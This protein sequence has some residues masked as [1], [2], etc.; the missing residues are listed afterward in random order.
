MPATT[1]LGDF[2]EAW[3]LFA[4][5][6]LTGVILG[7]VLGVLGVY[8]VLGRMVFLSAA[9]SQVAGF[10]VTLAYAAQIHLGIA[11]SLASPTLGATLLSLLCLTLIWRN[12]EQER[13]R[14]DSMLGLIFLVGSAGTLMVASKIIQELHDVKTLLFGSSVAVLPEDFHMVM[15]F[16]ALMLAIHIWWWRGFVEVTYDEDTASVRGMP[17]RLIKLVLIIT[18]AVAVSVCTRVLGALPAFAFSIFPAMAAIIVANNLLRA[19]LIA[20]CIG[21]ASGFLGYLFAFLYD[22]PVGP[23]Q[24]ITGLVFWCLAIVIAKLVNQLQTPSSGSQHV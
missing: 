11:A 23:S 17:V 22:F 3:P 14:R 7:A 15:V 1:S 8:I 18:I 13:A 12:S 4:D 10:G 16:G 6:V 19:M 20:A 5:A 2:W 24:A 21:G 9:L